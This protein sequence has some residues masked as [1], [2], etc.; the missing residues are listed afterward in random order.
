[1][2]FR[3]IKSLFGIYDIDYEYI[4]PMNKII[5]TREFARTRIGTK[6]WIHKRNYFWKTGKF[7]S[8]IMLTKDF[9][10]VDGYSSYKLAQKYDIGKVPVIFVDYLDE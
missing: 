3:W 5:I 9:I 10:L 6:K 8:Q 2:L 7:E 1:M 4:I